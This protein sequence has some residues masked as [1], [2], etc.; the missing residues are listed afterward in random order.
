MGIIFIDK[1]EKELSHTGSLYEI[2]KKY[3]GAIRAPNFE[4]KG[5]Q[6]ISW[7]P[8]ASGAPVFQTL[9]NS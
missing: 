3:M 7:E 2:P 6:V 8:R 5:A 4:E 1:Y 9:V